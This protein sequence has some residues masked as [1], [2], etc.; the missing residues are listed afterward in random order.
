M[1]K[2]RR[3]LKDWVQR[4]ADGSVQLVD[5]ADSANRSRPF[6][7]RNRSSSP[8]GAGTRQQRAANAQRPT[9]WRAPMRVDAPINKAEDVQ[10]QPGGA[11]KSVLRD[12]DWIDEEDTVEKPGDWGLDESMLKR[13][14]A[15][16]L[17]RHSYQM[18][19]EQWGVLQGANRGD[20]DFV[21][22]DDLRTLGGHQYQAIPLTR[23][24][25]ESLSPDQQAAVRYNTLLVNNRQADLMSE[26]PGE[27]FDRAQYDRRIKSMFGEQGGSD[28][29]AP[30]TV[31]LLYES[32]LRARGQDLDDFLSLDRAISA[33]ELENW[34]MSDQPD[35]VHLQIEDNPNARQSPE[36]AAEELEYW[37]ELGMDE[38]PSMK[39][40][41]DQMAVTSN[42]MQVVSEQ[43]LQALDI[44]AV[45]QAGEFIAESI[46]QNPEAW[47]FSSAV[48]MQITGRRPD[49]VPYGYGNPD[50]RD[51]EEERAKERFIQDAFV[52]LRETEAPTLDLIW[53]GIN[54]VGMDEEDID[55]L[56]GFID[57]QTRSQ[58]MGMGDEPWDE[59]FRDPREIRRIAGL[60]EVM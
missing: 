4:N 34:Q 3:F 14:E 45:Q 27:D 60:E 39:Y 16:D 19:N 26:G 9:S 59:E 32:G 48:E 31:D 15:L 12:L 43:N 7:N 1:A 52:Y 17:R 8:I 40:L 55:D 13:D 37:G 35:L 30:R 42:I 23:E 21:N 33:A 53:E 58:I 57:A 28:V 56:F 51:T 44:E 11:A 47:D 54:E 2:N 29:V 24:G 38:H 50:E 18:T 20:R 46:E 25:F 22:A 5:P 36:Q 49:D 41:H 6:F 10:S